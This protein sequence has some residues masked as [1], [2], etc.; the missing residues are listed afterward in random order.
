MTTLT[1]T[2]WKELE[3]TMRRTVGVEALIRW[4]EHGQADEQID[5][6]RELVAAETIA[7]DGLEEF[8][9]LYCDEDRNAI[10]ALLTEID[11]IKHA[12][13]IRQLQAI[14]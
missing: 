5:N 8:E 14:A 3:D 4:I 9:Q 6:Y 7:E 13:T 1:Y 10:A 2:E 11:P 12:D